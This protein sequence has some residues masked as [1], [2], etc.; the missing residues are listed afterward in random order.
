MLVKVGPGNKN[1]DVYFMS[2]I[3][4]Q[5]GQVGEQTVAP[6]TNMV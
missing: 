2:F 6:F 3:L 1:V 4:T 5:I